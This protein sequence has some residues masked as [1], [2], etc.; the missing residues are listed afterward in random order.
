[1]KPIAPR[2]ALAR[3]IPQQ[4][5]TGEELTEMKEKAWHRQELLVVRPDQAIDDWER[6]ILINIGNRLYGRRQKS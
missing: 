6:Q 1:M 5:A 2:C 3:M 4:A